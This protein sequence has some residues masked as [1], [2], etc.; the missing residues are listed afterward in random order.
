MRPL[1]YSAIAT[2]KQCPAKF[3]F[4]YNLRLPK[5]DA[6]EAM[7]RGSRLHESVEHLILGKR[8]D[9]PEEI[10]TYTDFFSELKALGAKAETPWGLDWGWQPCD[11]KDEH[12]MLRGFIDVELPLEEGVAVYELKTGK[13]YEEHHQQMNLY[14]TAKLIETSAPEVEVINIYLDQQDMKTIT[15][16]HHMLKEYKNMWDRRINQIKDDT[17]WMKCPSF[18]CRWCDYSKAK[19]GP[20]EF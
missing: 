15:Y 20:C 1:S 6:S 7:L 19:G 3:N 4:A 18:R 11:F 12:A 8:D 13:F 5:G 16:Q 9:L 10:E 14:A 2:Y 17:V